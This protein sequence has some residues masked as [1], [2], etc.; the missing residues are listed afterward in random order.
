MSERRYSSRDHDAEWIL[1]QER[2]KNDA[3]TAK[4]RRNGKKSRSTVI[5]SPHRLRVTTPGQRAVAAERMRAAAQRLGASAADLDMVLDMLGLGGSDLVTT[6]TAKGERKRLVAPCPD[7]KRPYIQLRTDGTFISHPRKSKQP[8][9]DDTR[10]P[11]TGKPGGNKAHIRDDQPKKTDKVRHT[12]REAAPTAEH[13]LPEH[14]T[15]C[16]DEDRE[17]FYPPSYGP[18]Y[19]D[20]VAQARAVCGRCPLAAECLQYALDNGEFTY[21]IWGGTT[22][23]ERKTL[24]RKDAA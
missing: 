21:G 6:Y 3:I 12:V 9:N 7:C 13:G 16:Q 2:C 22:P 8:L 5:N 4:Q 18:T 1:Q 14:R 10:C 17:L 23:H 24:A 20:Q 15:T 19:A 11:G